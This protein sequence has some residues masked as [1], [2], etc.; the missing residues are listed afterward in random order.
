MSRP[1]FLAVGEVAMLLGKSTKWVYEH[2]NEI[3]GKI[4]IG[5]SLMW[6][7]GLLLD[8]L[9]QQASQSAGS[10]NR[11]HCK[12]TDPGRGGNGLGQR[13]GGNARLR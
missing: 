4:K 2:Q 11:N 8:W 3:N 1:K 10:Q 5:G 9:T 7:E 13:Y 12:P 6:H